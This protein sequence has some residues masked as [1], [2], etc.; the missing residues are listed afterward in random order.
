MKLQQHRAAM[1]GVNLW[2][3]EKGP[4]HTEK[5][6][7]C[8]H[9]CNPQHPSMTQ[10]CPTLELSLVLHEFLI[11]RSSVLWC[12]PYSIVEDQISSTTSAFPLSLLFYLFVMPW[13]TWLSF[14]QHPQSSRIRFIKPM[15]G[16]F[17]LLT[18]FFFV[19]DKKLQSDTSTQL[20]SLHQACIQ[21][22]GSLINR[23]DPFQTLTE[24]C[25]SRTRTISTSG[26]L[27]FLFR[28]R[29][30]VM[31]KQLQARSLQ[32]EIACKRKVTDP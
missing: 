32:H 11:Y 23:L 5:V 6:F 12:W 10:G 24:T 25:L 29:L 13:D 27:V 31:E 14:T 2:G 28:I 4:G 18:I 21:V 9:P 26:F 15:P 7:I 22:I 20:Q 19:C 1:P 16:V 3:R 30:S 8:L 17:D